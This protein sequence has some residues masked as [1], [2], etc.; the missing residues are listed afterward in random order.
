MATKRTYK[1]T[2]IPARREG[3]TICASFALCGDTL[4]SKTFDADSLDEI[5][6]AVRTFA[7]EYGKGCKTSIDIITGRKPA[8]F[9]ARMRDLR[10]FN[11]DPPTQGAAA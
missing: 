6:D 3:F 5:A 9:D 8:G 2:L 10:Y 7:T 1:V 4:P 11:I